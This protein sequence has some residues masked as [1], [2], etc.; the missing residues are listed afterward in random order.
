LYEAVPGDP[1]RE[2]FKVPDFMLEMIARGKLGDKTGQGF[3]K[4]V[5]AAK[6]IHAIDW[7]TIEYHPAKK[8]KYPSVE[9]ARNI[10]DLAQRLRT[11]VASPDRVGFFLWKLLR[12]HIVYSALMIPEIS[13]RIVEIDRAMRWGYGHSLGPFELWDAL[14]FE[15]T[16]KRILSEGAALPPGVEKMLASGATSFYRDGEYFDLLSGGY[17][18]LEPR[19]GVIE[20][21]RAAVV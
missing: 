3:Y 5:G 6:E 2:R 21:K 18:S 19:P 17:R 1:F 10:E 14:G 15:A 4:R 13:D 16:A 11:L 9:M 7:R 8:P 12:D 20:L